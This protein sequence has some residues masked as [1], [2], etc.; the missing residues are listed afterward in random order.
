MEEDDDDDD[1]EIFRMKPRSMIP[2]TPRNPPQKMHPSCVIGAGDYRQR[3][4]LLHP[5]QPPELVYFSS[6][7][8]PT[9][10]GM[11]LIS[12]LG[13]FHCKTCG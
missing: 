10:I 8:I 2:L 7:H 6:F 12:M 3:P 9:A 13:N 4:L 1:N 5:E 11:F